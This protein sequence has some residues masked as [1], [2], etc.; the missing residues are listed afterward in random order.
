MKTALFPLQIAIYNRLKSNPDLTV[1]DAVP[2]GAAFPYVSIGE[3]TVVDE[4]TKTDN[5]EE[6]THTLHVYSSY[7]GRKEV[8]EI[9]NKVLETL[10]NEPLQL[11]SGF[12]M[13]SF[14]LDMMQVLETSGTPLKHGVMRF[15]AKINH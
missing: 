9:M 10:T 4:S 13:E 15:R 6:I 11:G 1:Y 7:N 3:D 12:F 14:N 8:K 5:G 2:E